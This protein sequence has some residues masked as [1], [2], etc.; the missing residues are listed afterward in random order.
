MDEATGFEA[1]VGDTPV[2]ASVAD[3]A[4]SAAGREDGEAFESLKAAVQDASPDERG[5][6]A[7]QLADEKPAYETLHRALQE[8]GIE[9]APGEPGDEGQ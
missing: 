7:K 1:H 5:A 8:L 2:A 9:P 6:A 4:R 3:Q